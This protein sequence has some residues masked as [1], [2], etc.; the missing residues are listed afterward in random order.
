M[1]LV[2]ANEFFAS[3]KPDDKL[4]MLANLAYYLTIVARDTYGA[5]GGVKDSK[6]LRSLIEVQHRTLAMLCS[7][8]SGTSASRMPD[9]AIVT[10]FL[11]PRDDRALA[12]LLAFT[13]KQAAALTSQRSVEEAP[14]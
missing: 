11:G 8:V 3:L 1:D 2:A 9:E 6:R 10:L 7:L 5:D 13:F 4:Q 12:A 14:S